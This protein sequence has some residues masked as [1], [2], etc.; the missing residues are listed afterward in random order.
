MKKIVCAVDF[1]NVTREVVGHAST[2]AHKFGAELWLIHVAPPDL[3]Y[4]KGM[5]RD[6]RGAVAQGLHTEHHWLQEQARELRES[7]V[8][9]NGLLVRGT[10]VE[11]ILDEVVKLKAD[12]IVMGSHG[13]TAMYRVL[14]GSVS[15]GVLR[16][17]N[18]PVLFVPAATQGR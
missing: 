10:P 13:H 6:E 3:D 9:A 16:G 17:A 2:L 7:G 18:V 5:A 11:A 4:F 1:S 14:V 15:E 8:D 12:L